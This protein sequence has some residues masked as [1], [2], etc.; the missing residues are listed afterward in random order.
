MMD[1]A[2]RALQDKDG[3]EKSWE[4]LYLTNKFLAKMLRDKMDKEMTKFFMVES[5]FKNIKISTGVSDAEALVSKFLN[6]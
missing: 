5:A 4:K 2:E 1:I 3:S 6:K